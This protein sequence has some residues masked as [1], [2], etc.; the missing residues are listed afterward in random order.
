[1]DT[2]YVDTTFTQSAGSKVYGSWSIWSVYC[3]A[4]SF[5]VSASGGSVTIIAVLLEVEVGHG[6]ELAVQVEQKVKVVLL[7]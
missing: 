3:N 4:S 7:H 1:M 5:T 6:M 2:E